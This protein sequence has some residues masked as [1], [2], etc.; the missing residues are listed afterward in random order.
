M[1][2]RFRFL[3]QIIHVPD[4]RAQV[5]PI[6]LSIFPRKLETF[7][8]LDLWMKIHFLHF[9]L[10]KSRLLVLPQSS[11]AKRWS[12]VSAVNKLKTAKTLIHAHIIDI[13]HN[14]CKQSG[15]MRDTVV[16]FFIAVG[17][18]VKLGV[19]CG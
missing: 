3:T 14:L 6:N 10:S 7:I 1:F 5:V 4:L 9:L 12:T 11:T 18:A 15:S 16:V 13:N 2:C 17:L 8:W 19:V